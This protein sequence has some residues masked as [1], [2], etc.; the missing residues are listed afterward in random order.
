MIVPSEPFVDYLVFV[1]QVKSIHMHLFGLC[2]T[3]KKYTN[4][5]I[6]L[7]FV[8]QVKIYKCIYLFRLC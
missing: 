3:G 6:Y 2:L 7:V 5:F 4:V 1:K 8:K